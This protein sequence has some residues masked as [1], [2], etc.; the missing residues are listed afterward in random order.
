MNKTFNPIV[1]IFSA[2]LVYLVLQ[3]FDI[4]AVS[5]WIYAIFT[6][7]F[8]FVLGLSLLERKKKSSAWVLKV[9]IS[10]LMMILL[11]YQMGVLPIAFLHKFALPSWFYLTIYI[12]CGWAFF[13]D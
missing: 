4:F 2:C 12:W 1:V 7:A 6:V 5:E 3:H 10:F 8:G 13:R 9:L 11:F